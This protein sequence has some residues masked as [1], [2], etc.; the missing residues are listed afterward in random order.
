MYD[1]IALQALP[2]DS[3]FSNLDLISRSK[4]HQIVEK[5]E[6]LYVGKVVAKILLACDTQ[7]RVKCTGSYQGLKGSATGL[8]TFYGLVHYTV[9]HAFIALMDVCCVKRDI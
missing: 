4:K 2:V 7:H 8:K 6:V 3:T 9:V 1:D 5:F